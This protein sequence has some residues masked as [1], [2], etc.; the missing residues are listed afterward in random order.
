MIP[1]GWDSEQCLPNL[2]FFSFFIFFFLFYFYFL[3]LF[4]KSHH[5]PGSLW[6][7][8][9][10]ETQ[11]T[12]HPVRRIQVY[13]VQLKKYVSRF[14]ED[15]RPKL[16]LWERNSCPSF[17]GITQHQLPVQ[18]QNGQSLSVTLRDSMTRVP[19]R[20]TSKPTPL[21]SSL[22]IGVRTDVCKI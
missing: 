22:L 9:I 13:V 19:I 21:I 8:F 17:N 7:S 1:A 4:K 12:F 15:N 11:D 16:S 6:N 10:L 3:H 5:D 2:A 14:L 18:Q 20:L